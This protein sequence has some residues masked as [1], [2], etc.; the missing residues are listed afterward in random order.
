MSDSGDDLLER[1]Q[2]GDKA[3]GSKLIA[4]QFPRIKRFFSRKSADRDMIEELV[5]RTFTRCLAKL[6]GFRGDSSFDTYIY[7]IARNILL[8][9]Y[10]E[11]RKADR[12]VV[13]E[14]TPMVD[15]DPGPFEAV[16]NKQERKVLINALRR[17][18]LDNQ[19]LVELY[20]FERLKG[21]EVRRIVGLT[22]GEFRG[23][24]RRARNE[25]RKHIE[26]LAESPELLKS[27]LMTLNTWANEVRDQI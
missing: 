14:E 16:E 7:G 13:V 8:E 27:T 6:P 24:I 20:Y 17:L 15:L 3:A 18:S 22:E 4:Q 2:R 21:P 10:R 26:E 12:M 11:R 23:R 25:L 19:I 9:H 1:W 5:Q